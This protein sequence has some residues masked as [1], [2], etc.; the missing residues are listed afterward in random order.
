M[1]TTF[2]DIKEEVQDIIEDDRFVSGGDEEDRII[3]YANDAAIAIARNLIIPEHRTNGTITADTSNY[4]YD[5][6]SDFL[7]ILPNETYAWV[8][9]SGVGKFVPKRSL[10]FINSIDPGHFDTTTSDTPTYWGPLG[11]RIWI[12]PMWAG[13]LNIQDYQRIPVAMTVDGSSPDIPSEGISGEELTHDVIVNFILAR[14]YRMWLKE[15]GL[16][17][18]HEQNFK[19]GLRQI[20]EY[21][22]FRQFDKKASAG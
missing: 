5:M 21:Y 11:Q 16:A 22:G 10:Q 15:P 4:R 3:N 7:K 12:Y 8:D 2:G 19:Q 9:V 1:A 17:Q 14:I 18:P 20:E 6:P 13:T